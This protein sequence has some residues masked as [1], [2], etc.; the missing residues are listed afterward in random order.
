MP[1]CHP[2]GLQKDQGIAQALLLSPGQANLLGSDRADTLHFAEAR[3]II[4][5]HLERVEAEA[6]DEPSGQRRADTRNQPGAEVALDALEGAGLQSQIGGDAELPAEATVLLPV[7]T[8]AK[9]LSWLNSV[10]RALPR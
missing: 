1:G 8:E 6:G 5:H 4:F 2:L 7:A 10:Q 9:T 3:R